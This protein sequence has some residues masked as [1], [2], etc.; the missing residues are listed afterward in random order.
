VS[1]ALTEL[2]IS[3]RAFA[4]IKQPLVTSAKPEEGDLI[5]VM[6][7]FKIRH[8]LAVTLCMLSPLL[9]AAQEPAAS[10][11]VSYLSFEVPGSLGTFPMSIN[12]SM[13]VT[14]YYFI[15]STVTRGFLREPDGAITTF[16]VLGGVWTEPESINAAGDVSGFYEVVAGVPQGFVRYSNGR[17][18]TFD[19]IGFR[20]NP[21]EAQPVS[22]NDFGVIAGNYPFPLAASDGFTRSPAG[23]FTTIGFALGAD[24]ETVVTGLNDSGTVV[25]YFAMDS[26]I[27]SFIRHPDGFSTQFDVPV[28][29]GN[30]GRLET[31]AE[32]INADG[33]VAGRYYACLQPCTSPTA[34]GFVRSPQGT[35]TLFSPPGKIVDLPVK[36][37]KPFGASITA[38]H[39]LSINQ[40][41]IITGSYVDAEGAQH[42]F[43]RNP[44]GTITS[45]DPPRSGQTTATSINDSGV[46]AG[47][48]Y[49][50]WNNQIAE[51]FLRLP[52]P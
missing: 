52:K 25:G 4:A 11:E 10:N 1:L 21:P 39:Q 16:D 8:R 19:P 17:I 38:Q 34:G 42:G 51:G 30:D 13:A 12:D 48:Y 27:S 23:E 18:V 15:S 35:L 9:C 26:N 33:V 3:S 46:I 14:G 5:S 45:F 49:Y 44:Y 43:V 6:C 22:I 24:Y 20:L 36:L 29:V 31:T 28:D 32:S 2:S 37:D 7:S 50:D 41:G 47:S 40:A